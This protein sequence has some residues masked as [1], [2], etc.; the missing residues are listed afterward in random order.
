MIKEL[1]VSPKPQNK[2]AKI[3]FSVAMAIS[4]V[5]FV[6][7]FLMER[8]R[9]IVGMFALLT[10]V[11]AILFYTKYI[12]PVFFYDITF[13]S[14]G[15]PIFVVRQV[16]GKRQTTLSRIDLENIKKIEKQDKKEQ[17]A[18]KTPADF[19]KYVYAPTLFPETVYR[20]TVIGRYEKAEIIV[21]CSDEYA[22]Y[23]RGAAAEAVQSYTEEE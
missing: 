20:I 3:A 12:A 18:H 19:R 11:T 2:N 16:T 6:I 13:D 15:T 4:F 14:E 21:E 17:S 9:G 1:T 7:Y 23:L 5:A 8:F 22:D 10:L